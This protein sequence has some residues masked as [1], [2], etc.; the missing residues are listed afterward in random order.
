MTAMADQNIVYVWKTSGA[1]TTYLGSV[2]L[3]SNALWSAG[4]QIGMLLSANGSRVD[5]FAG[6]NVP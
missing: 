1:T 6:A 5:N 2:T 4:G 3:P